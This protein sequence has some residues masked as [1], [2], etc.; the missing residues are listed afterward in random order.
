[1]NKGVT[2]YQLVIIIT[3]ILGIA[4]LALAWVFMKS[5]VSETGN[6]FEYFVNE[7]RSKICQSMGTLGQTIG[8][9]FGC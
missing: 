5:T 9:L 7:F 4:F 8:K 1:M 2:G 6:V 3:I